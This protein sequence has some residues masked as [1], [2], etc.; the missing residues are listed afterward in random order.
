MVEDSHWLTGLYTLV[1]DW[2]L[3][4]FYE[5]IFS[6]YPMWRKCSTHDWLVMA[7][8]AALTTQLDV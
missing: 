2:W 6:E 1:D 8:S 3:V 7:C 5:R 4:F